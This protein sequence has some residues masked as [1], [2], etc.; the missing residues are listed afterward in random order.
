VIAVATGDFTVDALRETGADLVVE[1]LADIDAIDAW[2]H[3]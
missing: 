3:A 2:L 1:T